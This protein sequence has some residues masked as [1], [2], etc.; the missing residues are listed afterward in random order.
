MF[1]YRSWNLGM[2]SVTAFPKVCFLLGSGS[3]SLMA[4]RI[5]L[6]WRNWQISRPHWGASDA[7]SEG[8][9]WDQSLHFPRFYCIYFLA[10]LGLHC[11]AGFLYLWRGCVCSQLL[12]HVWLFVTLW[13]GARL[14]PLSM[15]FSRQEYWSGLPFPPSAPSC[16]VYKDRFPVSRWWTATKNMVLSWND[17]PDFCCFVE[18]A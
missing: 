15:G 6:C 5:T 18:F 12:S 2:Y 10:V 16:F 13:T 3:K 4:S 11:C 1:K 14:D 17:G 9:G 8:R 7:G